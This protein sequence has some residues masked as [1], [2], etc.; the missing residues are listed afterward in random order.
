MEDL[1][2]KVQGYVILP[3]DGVEELGKL[4]NEKLVE[5]WS[6]LKAP[7][8]FMESICQATEM[9]S[10]SWPCSRCPVLPFVPFVP[11]SR[12]CLPKQ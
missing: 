10:F 1:M 6:P 3:G 8:V 12:L 4:V 5:G 2:G 11:H 7:F 9:S